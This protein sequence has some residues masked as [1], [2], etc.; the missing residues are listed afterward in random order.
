MLDMTGD[1]DDMIEVVKKRFLEPPVTG[2]FQP[3]GMM[4]DPEM[5]NPGT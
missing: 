4:D 5:P 3:S 1:R 2:A